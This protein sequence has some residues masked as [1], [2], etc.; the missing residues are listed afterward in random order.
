MHLFIDWF[1]I[2][3]VELPIGWFVFIGSFLDEVFPPIPSPL[4]MMIAAARLATESSSWHRYLWLVVVGTIG[5]TLASLFLYWVGNKGEVVVVQK[6]G[7]WLRVSHE[8]IERISTHINRSWKDD[9]LLFITRMLPILPTTVV[10]LACGVFKTN[11]HHFFWLT[12]LGMF[13]RNLLM[14]GLVIYGAQELQELTTLLKSEGL[15]K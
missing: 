5:K 10:S 7:R 14:L 3:V 12:L 4:V 11:P 2:L 13:F 8:Q 6:Y 1:K 9:V 15:I